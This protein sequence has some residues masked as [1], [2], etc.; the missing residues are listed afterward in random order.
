MSTY[1]TFNVVSTGEIAE[2]FSE[3][4][5]QD[6]LRTRLRLGA[7]QAEAF[8]S[9]RRILKKG[10]MKVD[11]EKFSGQ[12]AKLGIVCEIV[13]VEPRINQPTVGL[14]LVPQDPDPDVAPE[15]A[16]KSE[17]NPGKMM[18]CPRC[19]HE[20]AVAEQCENCGVWFHKL[21]PEQPVDG[22][23]DRANPLRSDA[24]S[25]NDAEASAEDSL[26]P[27][28]IA[29]A[30]GAGLVGALAWKWIAVTFGYELGVVAW[31][32][33]GAVGFAAA[34]AGSRGVK[35]GIICGMLAFAAIGM[36]KYWAAK[37]VI[38]DLKEVVGTTILS[39]DGLGAIYDEYAE[40]ARIFRA[41]SGSDEFVRQFMVDRGYTEA[42]RASAISDA[43]LRDFRE[44]TEPGL[45]D[46]TEEQ[47]D[48]DAWAT[49]AIAEFE[50]ISATEVMMEGFGVLDVLFLLLGVGTAFR[51]GSQME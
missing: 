21:E 27:I 34:S 18:V 31:G 20:Q 39:E 40:D 29:A 5:V 44:Y 30:A 48:T 8:F 26:N 17:P 51:L 6:T 42:A 25:A 1:V 33:G 45:R 4:A 41:G 43:E 19:G 24:Q 2:G 14:E 7:E 23:A 16:A 38:D 36:G 22:D 47:P 12:L 13:K 37:A 28:A 3:A 46:F 32:I 35:A 50:G 15:A 10:L 9:K 11:A 49:E